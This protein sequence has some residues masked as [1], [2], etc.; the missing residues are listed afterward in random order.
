M[1]LTSGGAAPADLTM[2]QACSWIA[3]NSLAL[4]GSD[5]S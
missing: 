3:Q 4:H 1:M 5:A 2:S